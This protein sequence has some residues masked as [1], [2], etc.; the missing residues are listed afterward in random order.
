MNRK[1][2]SFLI[3]IVIGAIL[4]VCYL[5]IYSEMELNIKYMSSDGKVK[6]TYIEEGIFSDVEK[7]I[8]GT[9][10]ETE[11]KY[12][13]IDI[14]IPYIKSSSIKIYFEDL[15]SISIKS[16][17][18]KILGITIKT[19]EGEAIQSSFFE[20]ENIENHADGDN[21]IYLI[22]GDTPY[23]E[24][25]ND[26]VNMRIAVYSLL[27][28][29]FVFLINKLYIKKNIK[30]NDICYII[31]FAMIYFSASVIFTFDSVWYLSYL[32][33]FERIRG[34]ESW[35][36]IRGFVF[37]LIIYISRIFAFEH[38]I[39][40]LRIIGCI[41]YIT[42]FYILHKISI[43][44]KYL[45]TIKNNKLEFM[46]YIYYVFFIILNPIIFSWYHFVLT[47][48]IAI[49]FMI[50]Y[51]K[52]LIF[53]Y[54]FRKPKTRQLVIYRLAINSCFLILFWFLKQMYITIPFFLFLG[55]ESFEII[56]RRNLKQLISSALTI[57]ISF[58]I[59]FISISTFKGATNS[60][61]QFSSSGIIITGLRYFPINGGDFDFGSKSGINYNKIN[62]IEIKDD[63]Y[64]TITEFKYN[65]EDDLKSKLKFWIQ[66]VKI[67]P[68]RVFRGYID[69]YLTLSGYYTNPFKENINYSYS[70]IN[71]NF[72]SSSLKGDI[73]T[74]S[75]ENT[76]LGISTIRNFY[77]SG[78][79]FEMIRKNNPDFYTTQT[80]EYNYSKNPSI[81]SKLILNKFAIS[82]HQ[83]LYMILML[84]MIPIFIFYG[85]MY[86][87][88][89]N[90]KSLYR[91][92]MI[93][94]ALAIGHTSV[95][96]IGGAIIDRYMM[97]SYVSMIIVVC[98]LLTKIYIKIE[99]RN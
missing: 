15:E 19:I 35:E 74:L 5:T 20:S 87:K 56:E 79:I 82:I 83:Y 71:K 91:M 17:K 63:Y 11:G 42:T 55:F 85:I 84:A 95:L 92:G 12:S 75:G 69:N 68:E 18:F 70:S 38:Y 46:I 28:V 6:V 86:F 53:V 36:S 80:K 13:S 3:C 2:N 47:E 72:N 50:I 98:D 78:E 57:I 59:L 33:F 8:Y 88:F 93:L 37:P 89:E 1:F 67:A 62:E 94:S 41:S 27:L 44:R 23:I 99:R 31:I 22:T 43:E 24:F 29:L 4:S 64:N 40:S 21:W 61:D 90:K 10:V 32:D 77:D 96:V 97:P 14:G 30:I 9:L 26:F 52:W 25:K 73:I 39:L 45:N 65:F 60:E 66:C 49:T 81:M 7:S 16:I 54:D 76:R 48:Y 34:L 51:L 58:S